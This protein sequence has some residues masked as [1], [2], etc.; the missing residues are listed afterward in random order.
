MFQIKVAMNHKTIENKIKWMLILF[1]IFLQF[2]CIKALSLA[3]KFGYL[4]RIFI[5]SSIIFS[6][7]MNTLKYKIIQ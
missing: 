3:Y 6:E 2:N 5:I 7:F 1:K 4:F